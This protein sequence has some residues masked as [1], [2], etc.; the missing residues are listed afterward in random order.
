MHH[1]TGIMSGEG[2]RTANGMTTTLKYTHSCPITKE[3]AVMRSVETITSPKTKTLEM[4]ATDPKSGKEY[5]KMR[6]ELTKKDGSAQA[7]G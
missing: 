2:E 7:G 4:F 1:G 5:K 6:V 3:P